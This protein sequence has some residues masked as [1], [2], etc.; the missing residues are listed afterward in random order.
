MRCIIDTNVAIHIRDAEPTVLDKIADNV[1]EPTLSIVTVVE[2]ENGIEKSPQFADW[3]RLA[4]TKIFA[5]MD[6][7]PFRIEEATR[8]GAIVKAL[9]YSRS[10][11][12]DRM[13]AAQAIVADLTLITMNPTDFANIPDLRLEVWPTPT[14]G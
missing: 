10:R 11:T 7:L 4:L 6:V 14:I 1:L 13:I 9:G 5:T 8:Y 12:L 2:L 3:R